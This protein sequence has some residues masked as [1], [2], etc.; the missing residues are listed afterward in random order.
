MDTPPDPP[1]GSDAER[2]RIRRGRNVA[3]A[4]TLGFFV[5]LVYLITYAR[6]G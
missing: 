6:M 5:V 1:R 4:L 3:L 2:A